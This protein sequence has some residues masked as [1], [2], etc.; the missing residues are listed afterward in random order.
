MRRLAVLLI[1]TLSWIPAA[2]AMASMP[3]MD[4]SPPAS[5]ARPATPATPAMPGMD[6]PGMNMGAPAA[7]TPAATAPR[8]ASGASVTIASGTEEGKK[9]LTATV[10]LKGKPVEGAKVAFY[11]QRTFGQLLLGQDDTLDDGTAVAPF[12][13]DLPSLTGE[14]HVLAQIVAPAAYTDGR[15]EATFKG[16]VVVLPETDPFPRALWSPH[17]PLGLVLTLAT[18]LGIVWSCY[19]FVLGQLRGIRKEVP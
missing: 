17:A 8:P 14:L 11:V 2:Q 12:P 19:F 18:F 6:M 4:M 13:S 9:V 5:T 16:G 15:G 1:L 7:T 10:T 3:G